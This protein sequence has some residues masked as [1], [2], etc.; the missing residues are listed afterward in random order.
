MDGLSILCYFI[1][2]ICKTERSRDPVADFLVFAVCHTAFLW[3][4]QQHAMDP[5]NGSGGIFDVYQ[6]QR[7]TW[8]TVREGICATARAFLHAEFIAALEWQV[9]SFYFPVES[10]YRI[11]FMLTSYVLYFCWLH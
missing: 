4:G 10:P 1:L 7:F 9:Y 8:L 6:Y 3:N 5:G 11:I 2:E